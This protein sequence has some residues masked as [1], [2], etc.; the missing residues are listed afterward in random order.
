[1][2]TI[3]FNVGQ[4]AS[5]LNW[6]YQVSYE[7]ATPLPNTQSVCIVLMYL[8][9]ITIDYNQILEAAHMSIDDDGYD[10]MG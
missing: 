7:V 2:N 5:L 6:T 3:W 1:M 8:H 9:R 4:L 10:M